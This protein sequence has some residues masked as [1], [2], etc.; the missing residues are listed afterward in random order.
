MNN[1]GLLMTM[2]I[3]D[4]LAFLGLNSSLTKL[5]NNTNNSMSTPN[6]EFH[7]YY[8]E[9]S[10]TYDSVILLTNIKPN[11][12]VYCYSGKKWLKKDVVFYQNIVGYKA[13]I[14]DKDCFNKIKIIDNEN[15]EIVYYKDFSH[16]WLLNSK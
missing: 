3:V 9:S 6:L 11:V 8:F 13:E 10:K 5:S 2:I 14:Y 1:S 12:T 16:E 7:K 4:V 15:K